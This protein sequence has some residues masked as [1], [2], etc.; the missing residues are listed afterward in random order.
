MLIYYWRETHLL[1]SALNHT[2]NV[3][4]TLMNPLQNMGYDLYTD[5]FYTSPQLATDLLRIGTTLTGTVMVN[6]RDLPAAVNSFGP[7][8]IFHVIIAC[9][10]S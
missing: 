1:T 3:V 10:A 6:K 4:L 2:T 8:L 7:T 5:Q 9:V